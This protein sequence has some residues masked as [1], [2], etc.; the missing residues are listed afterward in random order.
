M[1]AFLGAVLI[2]LVLIY[3]GISYETQ[4]TQTVV[5]E[6]IKEKELNKI[7]SDL[8]M[9]MLKDGMPVDQN[10]DIFSRM[11]KENYTHILR[12]QKMHALY[13]STPS[14]NP[15]Q[16]FCDA[17]YNYV[18][19][20]KGEFGRLT[21]NE[22]K[23][24]L[25]KTSTLE[26]KS[27]FENAEIALEKNFTNLITMFTEEPQYSNYSNYTLDSFTSNPQIL[28]G[29][30]SVVDVEKSAEIF[31]EEL[32]KYNIRK[33]ATYFKSDTTIYNDLDEVRE[34]KNIA[35]S[36][37]ISLDLEGSY[38]NGSEANFY[39]IGPKEDL[40][41]VGLKVFVNKYFSKIVKYRSKLLEAKRIS[42]EIDKLLSKNYDNNY[43]LKVN[44]M[45]YFNIFKKY[46][47][48][49]RILLGALGLNDKYLYINGNAQ[50][51]E[52]IINN[53][54]NNM[55]QYYTNIEE[56]AE[57]TIDKLLFEYRVLNFE[58]PYSYQGTILS[59]E[60]ENSINKKEVCDL[61]SFTKKIKY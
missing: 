17:F 23:Q 40:K 33:Y 11:C 26:V 42:P 27:N 29:A 3:Q 44:E 15:P 47:L 14:V 52:T 50:E 8:G 60:A 53:R 57:S 13:K 45:D 12:C 30:T 48:K 46:Y 1:G 34:E 25:V 6:N 39:Y 31:I 43:S 38:L 32:R 18:K 9:L 55:V 7:Y 22:L 24:L 5:I 54:N 21:I 19:N 58:T 28:V 61:E 56:L 16:V 49:Y 41:T 2:S 36:S 59:E 35:I 37:K 51:I 10:T 20:K 4:M